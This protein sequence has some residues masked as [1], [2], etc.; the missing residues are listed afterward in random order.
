ME[1]TIDR[2]GKGSVAD[3][4]SR[5]REAVAVLATLAA[6]LLAVASRVMMPADGAGT[7][8]RWDVVL[9]AGSLAAVVGI[10]VAYSL[11]WESRRL[12]L[13]AGLLNLVF[14]GVLLVQAGEYP[15]LAGTGK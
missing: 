13:A 4:R 8:R 7:H 12:A 6:G 15:G 14:L 3:C 1:R 10:V 11:G 2:P 5:P 9:G